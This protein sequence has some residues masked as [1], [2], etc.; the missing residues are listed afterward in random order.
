MWRPINPF[1][2]TILVSR[3]PQSASCR[4]SHR[5]QVI[6]LHFSGLLMSRDPRPNRAGVGAYTPATK[7]YDEYEDDYQSAGRYFTQE[8]PTRGN[9]QAYGSGASS[10]G[11]L[12]DRMKVKS[13]DQPSRTSVDEDYDNRPRQ[14]SAATWAR[15]PGATRQQAP[16][17]R[18]EERREGNTPF[19][20]GILPSMC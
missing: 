1:V 20:P 10:G 16:E 18:R 15:K 5:F 7:R 2:V 8:I 3:R 11:S 13:Y 4:F 17:P 6:S 9:G 12:L 14:P 19:A